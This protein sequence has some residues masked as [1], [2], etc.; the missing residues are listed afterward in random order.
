MLWKTS[1]RDENALFFLKPTTRQLEL[2]LVGMMEAST[3]QHTL[4]FLNFWM[5]QPLWDESYRMEIQLHFHNVIFIFIQLTIM[6][7]V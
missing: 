3:I 2:M 7:Q 5:Q 6:L 4:S 1:K